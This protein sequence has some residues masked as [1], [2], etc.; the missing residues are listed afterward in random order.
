MISNLNLR[1]IVDHSLDSLVF[2]Y[3]NTASFELDSSFVPSRHLSQV[4]DDLLRPKVLVLEHRIVKIM[5]QANDTGVVNANHMTFIQYETEDCRA[6]G[7]LRPSHLDW[8]G[9]LSF[10]H[11]RMPLSD[12][13]AV[14]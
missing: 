8:E 13:K 7:D 2:A 9:P 6:A 1:T 3:L 10:V 14:R 11:D 12:H 4:I 5:A